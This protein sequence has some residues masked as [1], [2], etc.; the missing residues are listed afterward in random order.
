MAR[1]SVLARRRWSR[2]I[3]TNDFVMEM[4]V[5]ELR[6]V[7]VHR[8]RLDR[9]L[10][11]AATDTVA[12][13][14]LDRMLMLHLP[15]LEHLLAQNRK[16]FLI[17]ASHTEALDERQATWRRMQRRRAKAARLVEELAVRPALLRLWAG[18]LDAI[19]KRVRKLRS[20]V[21]GATRHG[22]SDEVRS[23]RHQLH[24]LMQQTGESCRTLERRMQRV[25]DWREE[26]NDAQQ[27]LCEG[28]LRLVVSIAK[29]YI[30]RDI[31]FLD[32]IQEG[33][34]GLIQAAEKFDYQR[35]FKFSTYATWWIRQAMTRAIADKSRPI[36]LPANYQPQ[37]RVFEATSAKLMHE[38][39]KRPSLD[40]IAGHMR[41][42]LPEVERLSTVACPPRSLDETKSTDDCNLGDLLSDS[43][44]PNQVRTATLDALRA[45]LDSALC[46]LTE[47]ERNV[48]SLRYGLNDGHFRSLAELGEVFL[49][50]RE[51]VRQIEQ[52]ALAKIRR[53]DQAKP[54]ASFV[55]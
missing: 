25:Q 54:L 5:I 28:N 27:A 53:G 34:T 35:G 51:R 12:K 4:A 33:N 50:S 29:R 40:E 21:D 8:R 23:L 26:H 52:G 39:A 48:L 55:D 3:L 41:L 15:T 45:S 11:V 37:L 36:R 42:S 30:H 14:R 1:R 47:R 46:G 7:T 13:R 22:A 16:D 38:L 32:L 9:T 44:T 6:L 20:A 17:V 31:A 19:S 18:R 10:E 24:Q 43:R 49:V 2:A